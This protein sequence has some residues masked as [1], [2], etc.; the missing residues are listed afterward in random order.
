MAPVW[1]WFRGEDL[2]GG[3]RGLS[4]GRYDRVRN[5]QGG[6]QCTACTSAGHRQV[7]RGTEGWRGWGV[8]GS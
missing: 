7:C 8:Q 4:E 3:V 6:V 5:R 2:F 1:P